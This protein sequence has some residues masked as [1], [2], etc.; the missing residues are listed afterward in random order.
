[1]M[2]VDDPLPLALALQ[3]VI[4]PSALSPGNPAGPVGERNGRADRRPAERFIFR[5]DQDPVDDLQLVFDGYTRR[6]G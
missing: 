1:M 5:A 4:I 6:T 2:A 3:H